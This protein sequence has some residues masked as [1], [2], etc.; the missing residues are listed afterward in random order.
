MKAF[1]KQLRR[2]TQ[3]GL[4]SLRQRLYLQNEFVPRPI[5]PSDIFLVSFPKSGN[6]WVRFWLAN[7][8]RPEHLTIHFRTI[9]ALVP[10]VAALPNLKHPLPDPRF[11]KSH[12]P[13]QAEYPRVV[14]ILRDGRDAMLSYYYYQRDKLPAGTTLAHFLAQPPWPCQWAEHVASWLDADLPADKFLLLRYEEMKQDPAGQLQRL[15]QFSQLTVSPERFQQALEQSSFQA[16]RQ[17]EQQYGGPGGHN[18]EGGFMR[19]GQ[20]GGWRQQFGPAEKEIAKKEMNQMLIR[21]AY[22]QHGD[23]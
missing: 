16:M 10:P 11:I 5:R 8:L 7:L 2:K 19:Q 9:N 3:Q 21:L 23:W 17:A 18:P 12:A 1:L 20:S 14:Y 6:T 13:F 4:R 22:E 15:I